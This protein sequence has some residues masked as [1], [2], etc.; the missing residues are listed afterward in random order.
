MPVFAKAI[1]LSPMKVLEQ[2]IDQLQALQQE[3]EQNKYFQNDQIIT[4][5]YAHTQRQY[6]LKQ[7]KPLMEAF[8]QTNAILKEHYACDLKLSELAIILS[9]ADPSFKSAFSQQFF[10]QKETKFN[11]K[12]EKELLEQSC[13]RL[14]KCMTPEA[15]LVNFSEQTCQRTVLDIYV[16][17]Y[18]HFQ[19]QA[20]VE[21]A[22]LGRNKYLNGEL[23][24]SEFDLLYDVAQIGKVFFQGFKAA[25]ELAY[26]KYFQMPLFNQSDESKTDSV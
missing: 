16:P 4:N 1:E 15:F 19:D 10:F 6:H 17:L 21:V 13:H 11:Q 20:E 24:D 2:R 8:H 9:K 26:Y 18:Q 5:P 25:P 23:Y 3:A 7:N 12:G 14:G 22:G